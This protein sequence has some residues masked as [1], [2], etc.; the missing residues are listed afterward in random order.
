L[1]VSSNII[2]VN[3]PRRMTWAGNIERMG[4]MRNANKILV[5]KPEGRSLLGRFASRWVN[6]IRLTLGDVGWE[7]VD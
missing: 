3:N 6:N 7:C 5:G 2:K 4:E 1:Y